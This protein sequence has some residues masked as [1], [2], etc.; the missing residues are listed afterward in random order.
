MLFEL[1]RTQFKVYKNCILAEFCV[2][3]GQY[4]LIDSEVVSKKYESCKKTK[5]EK[6]DSYRSELKIFWFPKAH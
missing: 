4:W 5:N 2:F 6:S 1:Y 3:A